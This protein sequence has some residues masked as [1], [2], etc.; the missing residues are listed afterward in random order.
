MNHKSRIALRFAAI[1]SIA[2]SAIGWQAIA[3]A[4]SPEMT[5]FEYPGFAGR[6]LTV[7]GYT[8]NFGDIG[9]NDRAQSA[10]VASGTWEVC[11]DAAFRGS[12]ATLTRGEYRAMDARFANNISSAREIG[13]YANNTGTYSNYRRGSIELFE[14]ANFQGQSVLIDKDSSNFGVT[15]FNDRAGS[16][17]VREG[18][19]DMCTDADYRGACR[20]YTQGRYADLGPGMARQISSA[21]M[22]GG[23]AEAPY[24][25]GGSAVGGTPVSG[26]PVLGGQPGASYN[27]GTTAS[28]NNANTYPAASGRLILYDGDSLSGRSIAIT[29]NTVD[30]TH[31]GFNDQAVS[32]LVEKGRWELCTDP[33]FR[34]QCLVLNPG[35]Y[36]RL[37]PSFYRAISSIRWTDGHGGRSGRDGRGYRPGATAGVSG[38][39]TV[40]QNNV[41][42]ELFEHD[43]FQGRKFSANADVTDLQPKNFNDLASSVMIYSGQWEICT[44]ANFGGR[45]V[46]YGPGQYPRLVGLNDQFSSFRR[47]GR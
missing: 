28:A 34:G 38:S 2:I 1:A 33:Y 31:T 13:T 9:F 32:V 14:G 39:T 43:D 8:P 27:S 18:V 30:L 24:V 3:Y 7:R 40:A 21:R 6:S 17:V 42:I 41:D 16:A 26:A 20:T 47:V 45:C 29:E 19:W 22:S 11:T 37:D 36:R 10:V 35:Q 12:C 23:S 4:Q 25:L 44:D 5:F 46:V 15:G